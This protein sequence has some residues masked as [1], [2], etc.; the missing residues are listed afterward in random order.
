MMRK[1]GYTAQVVE[2]FNSFTKTR[3]DLF[4]CIDLIAVGQGRIVGVQACAGGDHA[5]RKAKALAEPRLKTWLESGGQFAV[6]SWAKRGAR[7]ERKLWT[8]RVEYVTR[9]DL[10]NS[11]TKAGV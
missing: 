8:A 4:G 11:D 2:K 5:K 6:V 10:E 7:G 1:D 3:L 9:G